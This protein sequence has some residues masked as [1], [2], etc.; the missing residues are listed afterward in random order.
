MQPS[1][2]I[3]K[4]EQEYHDNLYATTKLG[5]KGS[6]LSSPISSVINGV[7]FLNTKNISVLDIGCGV[8]RHCIPIAKEIQDAG[9]GVIGIDILA[10]AGEKL[11]ENKKNFGVKKD[12]LFFEKISI[13][14]YKIEKEQFDY[15]IAVSSLEHTENIKTLK[16]VLKK[17]T[18]GTKKGGINYIIIS[19]DN[20][21]YN[22]LKNIF[23]EPMVEKNL[24]G[25]E[26]K[27]LLDDYYKDWE[28]IEYCIK[29][30]QSIQNNTSEMLIQKGN[31]LRLMCRK[32]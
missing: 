10:L 28:I 3:R 21:L 20:T 22:P 31:S 7:N 11:E 12:A 2:K 30:W 16:K 18:Y 29:P 8:G 27:K 13:E 24:Q 26:A 14:D 5:E 23:L 25:S 1:K 15:I 19:V 9:G 32:K 4:Y 17:M 6:W